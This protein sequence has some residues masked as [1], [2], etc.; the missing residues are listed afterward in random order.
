[1]TDRSGVIRLIE[2]SFDGVPI[3]ED[4]TLHVAEAHDNY[5]YDND[6]HR[7]KDFVGRWQDVPTE[8]LLACQ[9]ALSHLDKHG[10]LFYLP[11]FMV[12]YIRCS[13]EA[14]TDNTLYALGPNQGNRGLAE[15]FRER[16]SLLNAAQLNACAHFVKLCAEGELVS[17][18][19]FAQQI[20]DDYWFEFYQP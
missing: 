2:E 20:F 9:Y 1:M 7:P 4:I 13:S 12:W 10:I 5:D 8:H 14:S 6:R 18:D 3:P 15:Y 17:D 11:A 16:F 19:T